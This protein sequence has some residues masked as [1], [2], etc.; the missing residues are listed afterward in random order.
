M[1]KRM[2][3]TFGTLQNEELRLGPGLNVIHAPNESGKSTWCAFLK[4][5]LYGIDSTQR[6]RSGQKPDKVK[7]APWSGASM[8]GVMELESEG[9]NITLRRSTRN[10][11]APMRQFSA[12]YTGTGEAVPWLDAGNV[13]E[14]LVGVPLGVYERSAFIRQSALSMDNSP[15]LEK[16][17]VAMVTTGEEGVS[18]TEADERLA[19]AAKAALQEHGTPS[20][21]RT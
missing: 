12:T 13:G 3:A 17:I 2:S 1:I 9:R 20:G 18:Y 19:P 8:E 4:A 10:A 5:M 6:E 7:Y 11:A 16:R 21:T 15:E 14:R